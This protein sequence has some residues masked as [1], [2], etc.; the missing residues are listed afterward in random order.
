MLFLINGITTGKYV[1]NNTEKE[2]KGKN[3]E[4]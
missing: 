4:D 3:R 2:E 1:L